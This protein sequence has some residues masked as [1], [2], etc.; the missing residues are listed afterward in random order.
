M[1]VPAKPPICQSCQ[2]YRPFDLD[3]PIAFCEAFPKAI[4]DAIL[5]NGFD[6]RK[7]F[8]GDN[9]IRFEFQPGDEK[10]LAAYEGKKT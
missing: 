3:H 10:M 8:P 7:P 2:R 9:G 4:P 5:N 1:T 6:H